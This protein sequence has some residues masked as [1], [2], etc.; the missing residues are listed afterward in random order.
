MVMIYI[1]QSLTTNIT[2]KTK[3]PHESEVGYNKPDI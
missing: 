3:K 1:K 2:I